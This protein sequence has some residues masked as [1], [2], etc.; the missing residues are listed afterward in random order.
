MTDDDLRA[1]LRDFKASVAADIE[2]VHRRLDGLGERIGSLDDRLGGLY[3]RVA[4]AE[5]AVLNELRS[6]ARRT[7]AVVVRLDRLTEMVAA[8][9]T[10]RSAHR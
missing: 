6:Q 10:D 3:D 2:R 1:L 9:V 7:E 5:V 8:H 4:S